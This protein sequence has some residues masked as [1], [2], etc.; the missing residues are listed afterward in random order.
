MRRAASASS[1]ISRSSLIIRSGRRSCPP[2]AQRARGH[3]ALQAEGEDAPEFVAGRDRALRGGPA[4]AAT[5]AAGSSVS[6]QGTISQQ[7]ALLVEQRRFQSRHDVV[8][9]TVPRQDEH[10]HALRL[11]P[12]VADQIE[13]VGGGADDEEIDALARHLRLGALQAIGIRGSGIRNPGHR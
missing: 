10:A 4:T 3:G 8:G 12:L 13:E 1:A 6:S 11:V 2:S 7:I 9:H 5:F